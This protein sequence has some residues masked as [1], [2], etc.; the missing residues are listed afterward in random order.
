MITLDASALFALIFAA[1][2]AGLLLGVLPP[3]R[4]HAGAG[5]PERRALPASLISL[6]EMLERD[7]RRGGR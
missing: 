4:R 7:Q 3:C 2:L 1:V 6:P 5:L